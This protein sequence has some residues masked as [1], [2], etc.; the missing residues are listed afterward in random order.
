MERRRV[1]VAG[2]IVPCWELTGSGAAAERT[3]VFLHGLFRRPPDYGPFLEAL[4]RRTGGARIVA[5]FLFG[6]G[7]LK[8]PPRSLADCIELARETLGVLEIG[9]AGKGYELLGHSTGGTVALALASRAPPPGRVVAINPIQETSFG[10]AG[11][12]PRALRIAAKQLG[13]S[14][15][16]H[17]CGLHVA[18]VT[19]PLCALNA[20][21]RADAHVPLV[22]SIAAFRWQDVGRARA[23]P[24]QLLLGA[25]DEFFDPPPDLEARLRAGPFP[26]AQVSPVT[27]V[28]SH[29]W[30]LLE[31]ERAAGLVSSAASP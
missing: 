29:E 23:L 18:L 22:Q 25:G 10:A 12:V 11:F 5:P 1:A 9:G 14:A 17:K 28:N 7:G 27:G 30:L 16:P 19:T 26:T 31:P 24:V 3:V 20:I 2:Q 8:R 21:W 4:A 6:N 13:G 15:G